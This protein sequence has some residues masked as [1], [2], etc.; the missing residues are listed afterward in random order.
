MGCAIRP[1]AFTPSWDEAPADGVYPSTVE[2]F[3]RFTFW[4]QRAKVLFL[5][6]ET[7]NNTTQ[8]VVSHVE[9][10]VKAAHVQRKL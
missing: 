3:F 7:S 6:T 9:F 1:R 10:S 4:A 2:A 5:A 8:K